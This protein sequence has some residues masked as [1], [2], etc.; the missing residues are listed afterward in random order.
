MSSNKEN[1]NYI[2]YVNKC[3]KIF[4]DDISEVCSDELLDHDISTSSEVSSNKLK[5]IFLCYK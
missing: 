4:R 3:L 5:R 2:V 1:D